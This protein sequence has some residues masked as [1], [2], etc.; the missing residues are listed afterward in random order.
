[1]GFGHQHGMG[2]DHVTPKG[3]TPEG[4]TPEVFTPGVVAPG[5]GFLY[6]TNAGNFQPGL[7]PGN[8]RPN[9]RRPNMH[10]T[11]GYRIPLLDMGRGPS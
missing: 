9:F 4:V 7:G 10:Q 11:T 6:P 2:F 5:V 3:V 8:F 1:M